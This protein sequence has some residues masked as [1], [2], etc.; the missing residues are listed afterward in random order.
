MTKLVQAII[1]L[2]KKIKALF[3]VGGP[4]PPPPPPGR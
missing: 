4:A 1:N 2:G 3:I